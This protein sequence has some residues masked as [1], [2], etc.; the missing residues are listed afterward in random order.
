[1]PIRDPATGK[2][3]SELAV[4]FVG[5]YLTKRD[6]GSLGQAA[7]A[8]LEELWAQIKA[9]LSR[10][11]S[12]KE[13]LERFEERPADPEARAE[14][15]HE[16][17]TAAAKDDQFAE[18]VDT[19]LQQEVDDEVVAAWIAADTGV[20]L[21]KVRRVFDV[22]SE[23]LEGM[24]IVT[25]PRD[26]FLYYRREELDAAARETPGVVDIDRVAAD[27]ARFLGLPVEES[28]KILDSHTRYLQMRGIAGL[29]EEA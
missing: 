12:S 4:G 3:A 29:E 27:A 15:E 19:W 11:A 14:L 7:D 9:E 20:E 8:K 21:D 28:L 10:R 22:E 5:A 17:Q 25:P 24:G 26:A 1:M 18:D 23:F 2:F 6:S 16:F 13:A